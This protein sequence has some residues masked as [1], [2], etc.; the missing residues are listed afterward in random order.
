MTEQPPSTSDESNS[1]LNNKNISKPVICL[2][3]TLI[4]DAPSDTEERIKQHP[5]NKIGELEAIVKKLSLQIESLMEKQPHVDSILQQFTSF[6][7]RMSDLENSISN[8]IDQRF[9]E[10]MSKIDISNLTSKLECLQHSI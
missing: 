8:L 9:T 10:L 5:S 3:S 7:K 4:F 6:Q 1:H 2:T